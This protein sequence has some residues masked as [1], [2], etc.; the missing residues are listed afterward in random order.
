MGRA[1]KTLAA[2]KIAESGRW[3]QDGS[4]S[5]EDWL[6]VKTGTSKGDAKDTLQTGKQLKDLPATEDALRKG[7]LSRKQAKTVADAASA[8]PSAEDD[9][10]DTAERGST[11]RRLRT[12]PAV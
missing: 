10:L 11:R 9:L 5:P 4:R 2:T 7:K 6:A 12:R 1:I 8:D 3:E